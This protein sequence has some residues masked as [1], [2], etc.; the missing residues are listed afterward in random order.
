MKK[1]IITFLLPLMVIG[2]DH[3]GSTRIKNL[4]DLTPRLEVE[5]AEKVIL[6][7]A[8]KN[9]FTSDK[10][11]SYKLAKHNIISMPAIAKN[12][13]YSV[14]DRGYVSAFS[15]KDKKIL[16]S[17]DIAAQALDRNFNS[18][19]ILYS[20]DRL[21][22]T[23]GSRNLFILDANN[24]IEILRKEFPDILRTKP[25]M[26]ND[27][28]LLV[29]T[30]SNQLLAYDVKASKLL[31]IHEG[32][33]ET[34]STK[35]QVAP[36][37]Y[38]D[39]VLVTYSSGEV[40]LIDVNSGKE[41]WVFNL[42]EMGEVGIPGFD[43]AMIVTTPIIN[44][45]YIYF[46]A[47]NGKLAKVDLDNGGAAWLTRAEDVQSMSL[48]GNN[49]FVTNNARQVAAIDLHDG[50][51][52][53]VGNLISESERSSKKPKPVLFQAPFVSE[54]ENGNIALNVIGSN[55]EL[56]QFVPDKG[57]Q[58]PIQPLIKGVEK[59]V[60]YQWFSCCT[61]NMYLITKRSVRF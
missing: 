37:V 47:S 49:L 45:N 33:L 31:W 5:K 24:G 40:I 27:R 2:C 51:V 50:K 20:D 8:K 38:K 42:T 26:A 59:Q 52:K 34:I 13:M 1:A 4:I 61:G 3:I 55:G 60:Q 10:T 25:V 56:Y 19:G 12:V 57:D 46:A 7:D 54:I 18:G 36:V 35:N 44:G 30:I 43:P 16:W 28:L 21:F 58:L 6:S 29:Q 53:W 9:P 11:S 48:F 39:S 41:K 17:T 22:V 14:D 23:N 15:L 32:G